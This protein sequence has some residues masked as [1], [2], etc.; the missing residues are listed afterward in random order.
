RPVHHKLVLVYVFG[1]FLPLFATNTYFIGTLLSSARQ[2]E[3]EYVEDS[4]G[5]IADSIER[6]LEPVNLVSQ[7]ILADTTIYR[8]ALNDFAT[9]NEYFEIHNDYLQPALSKYTLGFKAIS[10]IMIYVE[11]ESIGTSS[12]Y[13]T[14]NDDNRRSEWY[15]RLLENPRR[16][17]V[18]RHRETD[19]RNTFRQDT[20]L[21]LFRNMSNPVM[22]NPMQ[23]ILRIDI[24]ESELVSL[25]GSSSFQ[26]NLSLQDAQGEVIADRGST[27]LTLPESAMVTVDYPLSF[28]NDFRLTGQVASSGSPVSRSFHTSG[29]LMVALGSITLSLSFIV[30][31]SLSVTSR[32]HILSAHM[33]KVE[34]QD[35]TPITV[36]HA[37]K[38]EI[39][40]LMHDFNIMAEQIDVLINQVL[41]S[42]LRHKAIKLAQ[43]QAELIHLQSQINPHFLNNVLESIRMRSLLKDETETAGI[44]L[45]L[46]RLFRRMLKLDADLIPVE[47]ELDFIFEYIEI[48]RYRFNDKLQFSCTTEFHPGRWTIPKMTVQ[49][50]IENACIHGIEGKTTPGTIRLDIWEERD[51]LRIRI[52]DDGAGFDVVNQTTGIGFAN[53]RERLRLHYRSRHSLVV[54]SEPGNGTVVSLAIPPPILEGDE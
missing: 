17:V 42:E 13:M 6:Y 5:A 14:L 8:F 38:D 22:Q 1:I 23:M 50:F 45:K 53:I 31:L 48:Q 12:G 26:G 30:L 41:R 16:I 47:D 49:G 15:R 35:F 3:R 18:L 37:G 4:I 20:Y 25:L 52:E 39:G 2:Q 11:N 51:S 28:P 24:Q 43:K 54:S 32:I 27:D 46:S 29:F 10:R 7:A 9:P 33:K 36:E 44:M 40:H 21:S 34:D 19:A